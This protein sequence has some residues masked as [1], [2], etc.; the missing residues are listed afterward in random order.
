VP[1]QGA[2]RLHAAAALLSATSA[3]EQEFA[4]GAHR[5]PAGFVARVQAGDELAV[6]G[7]AD[8]DA[9]V[10]GHVFGNPIGRSGV[11]GLRAATSIRKQ[12]KYSR[13]SV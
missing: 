1:V 5:R 12:A 3:P 4:F 8:Q 2:K 9:L 13:N 6:L 11:K 10:G 7:A